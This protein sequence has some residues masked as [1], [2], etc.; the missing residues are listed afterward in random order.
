MAQW[1]PFQCPASDWPSSFSPTAVQLLPEGH[2][3]LSRLLIDPVALGI[4]C[5]AQLLPS[6]CSASIAVCPVPADAARPTAMQSSADGQEIPY[7]SP[8]PLATGIVWR[9]QVTPS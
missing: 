8:P 7:N 3:T 1:L 2:D 9:V 4:G 5:W 6:Q